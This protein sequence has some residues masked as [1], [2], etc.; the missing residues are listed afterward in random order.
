MAKHV[1]TIRA[2]ARK[3]ELGGGFRGIVEDHRNGARAES[4][5]LPVYEEARNWAMREAHARMGE[6]P[7]RRCSINAGTAGRAYRANIWA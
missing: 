3:V 1:M 2:Y 5:I 7:Y 6:A 4:D